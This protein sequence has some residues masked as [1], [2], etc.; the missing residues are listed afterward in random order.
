MTVLGVSSFVRADDGR[1]AWSWP[2]TTHSP[3]L[4]PSRDV[5]DEIAPLLTRCGVPDA[6]LSQVARA[7][8]ARKLATGEGP[9][10]EEVEAE[11][12][13]AG[14]PH[15]WPKAWVVSGPTLGDPAVLPK[16]AAWRAAWRTRG[17]VRCG[18]ARHHA[19]PGS[20]GAAA[21]PDVIAVVAVDALADLDPLPVRVHTGDWVDVSA[22]VDVE[23]RGAD[24]LVASPDGA[25][26]RVPSSFDGSRAHA[27]FAASKPGA[28]S[29]QVMAQTADGPRPV[30]EARVFADVE[31]PSSP[32]NGPAPG[33]EA[34]RGSSSPTQAFAQMIA[35]LRDEEELPALSRDG[36][37]D[38]VAAAHTRAMIRAHRVAHDL[39]DGDPEDRVKAAGI[40]ATTIGE[41]VAH[42]ANAA[43]A[44]RALFESPSHRANLLKRGFRQ[45]GI[46]ALP[47]P[48][49]SIWVT[50]LFAA[51]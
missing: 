28:F 15:V 21:T 32:E 41:N 43:L 37:L 7:L 36:A 35:A 1:P 17:V 30:L 22:H 6:A 18:A 12:R 27:R 23:A 8:V 25:P 40:E 4:Q 2:R 13:A 50:E 45:L 14:E 44:H 34:A 39:G 11:L 47:G 19:T 33:E 38:S 24:V 10:Q 31:P 46:S 16:L 26:L 9:A 20:A 29:V 42:A 5:A 49:G 48:D 51:E 3:H